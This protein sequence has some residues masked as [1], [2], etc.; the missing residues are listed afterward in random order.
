MNDGRERDIQYLALLPVLAAVITLLAFESGWLLSS[1]I[2]ILALGGGHVAE[3]TSTYGLY[4]VFQVEVESALT[5]FC[6]CMLRCR[7]SGGVG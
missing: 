2:A 7:S 1:V 4:H 6:G 3:P 5:L